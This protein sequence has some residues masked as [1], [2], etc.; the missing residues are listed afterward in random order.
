MSPHRIAPGLFAVLFACLSLPATAGVKEGSWTYTT[1]DV[2]DGLCGMFEVGTAHRF[3]AAVKTVIDT[4]PNDRQHAPRGTYF[5]CHTG[6]I[7]LDCEDAL[8]HCFRT[9][10]MHFAVPKDRHL[11]V[12]Q[13]WTTLDTHFEVI[14]TEDIVY[15]GTR[16]GTFVITGPIKDGTAYFYWSKEAGLLAMRFVQNVRGEESVNAIVVE[17]SRGYPF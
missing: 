15:L 17:E 1:L 16:H 9:V 3:P 7:L 14:R 8:Y 10:A 4:H 13:R 12:G 6:T 2:A 11:H 5:S